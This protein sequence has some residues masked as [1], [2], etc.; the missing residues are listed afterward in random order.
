M[1]T[2]DSGGG[3][4]LAG[5]EVA[6]ARTE[7]FASIWTW[8][9]KNARIFQAEKLLRV[10]THKDHVQ[11]SEIWGSQG[12]KNVNIFWLGHSVALLITNDRRK[13]GTDDSGGTVHRN[14]PVYKVTHNIVTL[15]GHNR[16][17]RQLSAANHEKCIHYASLGQSVV[18]DT[19][20]F[21][22]P[23]PLLHWPSRILSQCDILSAPAVKF[24]PFHATGIIKSS[25]SSSITFTVVW[26]VA[27]CS[28]VENG[29]DI[30]GRKKAH[31]STS[32]ATFDA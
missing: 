26:D 31:G 27:P 14:S 9:F 24:Q 15:E 1:G 11:L 7:P 3:G 5:T 28:L 13:S 30:S 10:L 21:S 18:A 20:L 12:L 19:E 8:G 29:K 17:V 32:H 25:Q 6:G 22:L 16:Q 23:S 4:A 2:K